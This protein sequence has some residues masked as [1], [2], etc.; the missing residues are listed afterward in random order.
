MKFWCPWRAPLP[1][2]TSYFDLVQLI[3]CI[4]D[5]ILCPL[6]HV[7]YCSSTQVFTVWHTELIYCIDIIDFIAEAE[8]CKKKVFYRFVF[9]LHRRD[10]VCVRTWSCRA[11]MPSFCIMNSILGQ[12]LTHERN[13]LGKHYFY[14]W[15]HDGRKMAVCQIQ[16]RINWKLPKK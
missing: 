11:R 8:H 12:S 6:V 14:S 10:F 16:I 5:L 9:S 7:T 4:V 13:R 15:T 1:D 2:S 3:H